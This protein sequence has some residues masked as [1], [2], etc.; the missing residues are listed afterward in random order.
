MVF[1]TT[2]ILMPT[3]TS[4]DAATPIIGR[5]L[6]RTLWLTYWY[7]KF[8]SWST[9]ISIIGYISQPPSLLQ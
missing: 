8:C 3:P 2:P 1:M 6:L 7:W 5:A 4:F 9:G